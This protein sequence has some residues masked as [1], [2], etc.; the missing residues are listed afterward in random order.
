[1]APLA[2][3][4]WEADPGGLV[5][6]KGPAPGLPGPDQIVQWTWDFKGGTSP[7]PQ[8]DQYAVRQYVT[9]G[10]RNVTLT[11]KDQ[12][13]ATD[14]ISHPVGVTVDSLPRDFTLVTRGLTVYA[15]PTKTDDLA[16]EW[17]W[18][19]STQHDSMLEPVHTY[20]SAGTYTVTLTNPPQGSVQ[21]QVTVAAE[22]TS[23]IGT[24]ANVLRIQLRDPDDS[25]GH[26]A[27]VLS[28]STSARISRTAGDVSTAT[29]ECLAVEADPSQGDLIRPGR[30]LRVIASDPTGGWPQVF[31]GWVSND[32]TTR[33]TRDGPVTRFVATDAYGVVAQIALSTSVATVDHL[34]GS[35]GF[36]VQNMTGI[37]VR[38]NGVDNPQSDGQDHSVA[39]NWAMSAAD[40]AQVTAQTT[41]GRVWVTRAGVFCTADEAH[42]PGRVTGLI[43]GHATGDIDAGYDPET[44][45]NVVTVKWWGH[46]PRYSVETES[47]G[48]GGYQDD[49]SISQWGPHRAEYVRVGNLPT[50]LGAHAWADRIIAASFDVEPQ[51]SRAS[52]TLR[53][54]SDMAWATVDL[55]DL[56]KLR[57]G[58]LEL[59]PTPV[60]HAEDSSLF[61][62]GIGTVQ[63]N[64]TGGRGGGPCVEVP[65]PS[66][67][68]PNIAC[69]MLPR[70][71]GP[72]VL[73][74]RV[75]TGVVAVNV[76]QEPA[77]SHPYVC[78][79]VFEKHDGTNVATVTGPTKNVAGSAG[80]ATCI[81]TGTAPDGAVRVRVNARVQDS[82][83]DASLIR[84]DTFRLYEEGAMDGP[85]WNHR[86]RVVG[87]DHDIRPDS[88]TIDYT[89]ASADRPPPP[90]ALPGLDTTPPVRS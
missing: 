33:Y 66:G 15:Y 17:A 79:L 86:A 58:R 89:L 84:F 44:L 32:V 85:Q 24:T 41:L 49:A 5:R 16:Y 62:S 52:V 65:L 53:H 61:F 47:F 90:A 23:E 39:Q 74:G 1:M 72:A 22:D 35:V 82:D 57:I 87:I 3:F 28:Q 73:P 4:V 36:L 67:Y 9:S 26:W 37:D 88:W 59:L 45:T 21:H 70:N 42:L 25:W 75:Y 78:E 8:D 29:V 38:F 56:V 83:G 31:Y 63:D 80:Y 68:S 81:A 7:L 43:D 13:G 40:Q 11:V 12:S 27:N 46:I 76:Q 34:A 50:D 69:G 77:Q 14:S 10:V 71:G 20:E 18:G 51:L 19:D 55:V 2:A 60:A 30:E 64:A 6:F 48:Y 54:E